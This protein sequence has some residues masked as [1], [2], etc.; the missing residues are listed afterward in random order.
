MRATCSSS[1]CTS[2]M[3]VGDTTTDIIAS[4]SVPT[5]PCADTDA[6]ALPG[7][8]LLLSLLPHSRAARCSRQRHSVQCQ[9]KRHTEV[10]VYLHETALSTTVCAVKFFPSARPPISQRNDPGALP[11][12]VV[13]RS[14]PFNAKTDS[15]SLKTRPLRPFL[16]KRTPPDPT[17][18]QRERR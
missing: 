1:T 15:K 13:S 5:V 10:S 9:I 6:F 4:A 8:L 12:A 3:S 14:V 7:L 18:T 17:S 2:G 16:P 11:A